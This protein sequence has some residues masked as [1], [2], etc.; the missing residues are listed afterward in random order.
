MADVKKTSEQASVST[1][2]GATPVYT[3]PQIIVIE[4]SSNNV[5]AKMFNRA[6]EFHFTCSR[7]VNNCFAT[8]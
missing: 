7:S 4:S 5:S 8:S 6:G 2:N 3:P 1:L